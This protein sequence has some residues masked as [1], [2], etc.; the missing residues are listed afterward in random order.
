LAT[1]SSTKETNCGAARSQG[2]KAKNSEKNKKKVQHIILITIF[3][4]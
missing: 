4:A 2:P 3:A 1:G